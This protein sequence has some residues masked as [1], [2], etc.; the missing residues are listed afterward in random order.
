MVGCF[1]FFNKELK[2]YYYPI[3]IG[4][5]ILI[6]IP[7]SFIQFFANKLPFFYTSSFVSILMSSLI[8]SGLIEESAKLGF[9]ALIPH[10][11]LVF[12]SFFCCAMLFGLTAGSFESVIYTLNRLRTGAIPINHSQAMKFIFERMI[13]AQLIHMFCS[14]LSGFFLW[15]LRKRQMKIFP[16]ILSIIIHGIYNFFISFGHNFKWFAFAAIIFAMIE[17]RQIYKEVSAGETNE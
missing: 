2:F 10:K 16:L 1:L 12:S 17:T 6:V 9:E 8:L 13:S 14:A 15:T 3:V 11:K 7:C 4:L 5:G